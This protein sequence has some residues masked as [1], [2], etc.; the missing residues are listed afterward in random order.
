M[1]IR[2]TPQEREKDLAS[3]IEN[4]WSIIQD[5]DAIFKQFKFKSFVE[6]FS[7]MTAAALCAEKMNH[8][9]EWSNVYNRVQVTL[10]THDIDGLS[11]LDI[12]LAQK[13]NQLAA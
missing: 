2:L 10:M 5:R 11:D 9:P 12:K 8:H 4:G 3:L 7:W 1:N 6:A 13:M